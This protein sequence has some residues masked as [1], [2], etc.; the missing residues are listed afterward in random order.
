MKTLKNI[1]ISIFALASTYVIGAT[2]A[3]IL[4]SCADVKPVVSE[5][6]LRSVITEVYQDDSV[7]VVGYKDAE[8]TKIAEIVVE[9]DLA[10]HKSYWIELNGREYKVVYWTKEFTG[11]DSNAVS[12]HGEYWRL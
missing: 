8:T 4:V 12:I 11:D 3:S 5:P 10:N 9:L 1:L 2:I 6:S 7:L